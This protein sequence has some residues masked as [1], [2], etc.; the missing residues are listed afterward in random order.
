MDYVTDLHLHSKYSRAV[1]QAMVLPEMALWARKKGLDILAA[2]DWTH[3]LWFKEMKSMLV[4]AYEG[5]YRLKEPTTNKQQLTTDKKEVLFLLSTEIASIYSQNGKLR[6]IHNLVMVPSFEIAEK[7]KQELLRRGCNLS[8]DGRPIIGI[9]SQN[10]LE[11]LLGID[12]RIILIPAHVWTPHFGIYGSASGFDSLAESFGSL[13]KFIYGV[14]TGLSSDPIMNWQVEELRDRAILSFSD[15]HSA[16]KMGREATVFRL[17]APSYLNL[18]KAI[19]LPM[20]KANT[21][22][23]INK[24]GQVIGQ[25]NTVL[26]T[27]EFYPE[28][29]KYHYTGHRN[30]GIVKSPEEIVKSGNMCP[31]CSRRLTEGVLLRVG[32]LAGMRANFNVEKTKESNSGAVWIESTDNRPPFIKL[33]PLNEIIAEAVSSPA[34]S[35]KVKAMFDDM[36]TKLG[37]EIDILLNIPISQI[38][39]TFGTRI[40]EGVERVRKGSIIIEPGYDGVYGKVKIWNE[41]DS[42][43]QIFQNKE[44]K[45]QLGLF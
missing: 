44:D 32:E 28:E 24:K 23:D 27:L 9:S 36:C 4:E 5:L 1:S 38:R 29:G 14:E 22:R 41:D 37:S 7:V 19:S 11:L 43:S 40:A 33:V 13:S 16:P 30:C 25:E 26:H 15:A 6:R 18:G 3:P 17:E 42:K 10:L 35:S 8:S 20:R 21:E 39:N 31:K 12:R 34:I 2:P 45:S